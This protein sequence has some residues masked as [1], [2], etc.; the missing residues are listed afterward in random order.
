VSTDAVQLMRIEE[1]GRLTQCALAEL[2]PTAEQVKAGSRLVR[3]AQ[4]ILS[5]LPDPWRERDEVIALFE[6]LATLQE[7]LA[8]AGPPAASVA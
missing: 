1:A 3:E 5:A 8:A 7:Q 2:A 4:A 6:E